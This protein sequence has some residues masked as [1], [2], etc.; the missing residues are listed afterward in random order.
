MGGKLETELFAE[1]IWVQNKTAYEITLW[2]KAGGTDHRLLSLDKIIIVKS[3]F[4][5]TAF[6]CFFLVYLSKLYRKDIIAFVRKRS[7]ELGEKP[8]I[9]R[10]CKAPEGEQD[11]SS[12]MT[13]S[14]KFKMTPNSDWPLALSNS[15]T[16]TSKG[17]P[18]ALCRCSREHLSP[19]N[20][21]WLSTF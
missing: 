6:H 8:M 18:I 1:L 12:T 5:E 9:P 2:S 19:L 11:V 4:V 16:G 20:Y 17:C 13:Q 10:E 7:V 3:C 15:S 21:S 14:G